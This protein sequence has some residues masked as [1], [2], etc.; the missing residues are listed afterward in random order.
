MAS[1]RSIVW[2]ARARHFSTLTPDQVMELIHGR[3]SSGFVA[4]PAYSPPVNEFRG[5]EYVAHVSVAHIS[6]VVPCMDEQ[7]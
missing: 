1:I 6:S 7:R 5:G 4:L 3:D 2:A